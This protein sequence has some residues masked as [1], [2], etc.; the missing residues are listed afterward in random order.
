V[1]AGRG[2]PDALGLELRLS[3][4]AVRAALGRLEA[5]GLVVRGALGA[6]E[7]TAR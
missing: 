3:A 2:G 4:A 7:R 1:E 6:Y 5:V